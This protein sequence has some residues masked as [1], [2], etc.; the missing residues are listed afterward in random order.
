M[1]KYIKYQVNDQRVVMPT[2]LTI[3]EP[4]EDTRLTLVTCW[5]VGTSL[6]RLALLASQVY[7]NPEKN[8]EPT[9]TYRINNLPSGR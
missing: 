4:T 8:K 1:T 2:D 7:P 3:M 6:K 5:P 9:S